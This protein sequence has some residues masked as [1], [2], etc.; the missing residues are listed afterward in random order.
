MDYVAGTH[1]VTVS[2]PNVPVTSSFKENL[3]NVTFIEPF[4]VLIIPDAVLEGLEDFECHIVNTSHNR[5]LIGSQSSVPVT[6]VDQDSK[7]E[8]SVVIS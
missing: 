4:D 7:S 8:Q 1:T 3:P 6:I 5:V 2:R